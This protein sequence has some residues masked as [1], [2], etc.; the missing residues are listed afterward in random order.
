MQEYNLSFGLPAVTHAERVVDGFSSPLVFE[1][2]TSWTY[3]G[4]LDWA[5]L[6][7]CRISG[8][9]LETYFQQHVFAP[10]GIKDITFWPEKHPDLAAR[11]AGV[12]LRDPAEENGKAV[13]YKGPDIVGGAKEE[14]GWQGL[15]ASM[16]SYLKILHSLLADDGKLLKRETVAKMFEPQLTKESREELQ[17]N[18]KKQPK[19]GPCSIG[20]FPPDIRY[21]W[22]LGGLLTMEDVDEDGL[23]WRRKGCMN[24]GGVLNCAWVSNIAD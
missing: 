14:L 20:Q 19:R 16:P 18:Y 8:G 22:G 11:R 4:G 5:G 13:P 9:D 6:L 24:W 15:Y 7:V 12:S 3:S 21:G 23:E 17:A 1:P 2:G 10:L